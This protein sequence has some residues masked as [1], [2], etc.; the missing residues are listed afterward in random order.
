[1]A[2]ETVIVCPEKVD[3]CQKVSVVSVTTGIF[4]VF[5]SLAKSVFYSFNRQIL[6]VSLIGLIASAFAEDLRYT[7]EDGMLFVTC[8]TGVLVSMN[9]NYVSIGV[10]C[11][12]ERSFTLIKYQYTASSMATRGYP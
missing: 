10:A 1:M 9:P 8:V 6:H 11:V 4:F 12:R 2:V 5:M 7:L 3:F